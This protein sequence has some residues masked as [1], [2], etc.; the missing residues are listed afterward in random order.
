MTIGSY[1]SYKRRCRPER[2]QAIN[3]V[4]SDQTPGSWRSLYIPTYPR[5][6]VPQA[7]YLARGVAQD[8][9]RRSKDPLHHLRRLSVYLRQEFRAMIRS[10]PFPN[11]QTDRLTWPTPDR[12]KPGKEPV[13]CLLKTCS[14][15]RRR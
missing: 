7:C 14:V 11:T 5:K 3:R 9:G 12:E 1:R 8:S 13:E 2:I 4:E 15:V 10:G 6:S